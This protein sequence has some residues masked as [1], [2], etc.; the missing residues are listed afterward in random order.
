MSVEMRV[1]SMNPLDRAR[2]PWPFCRVNERPYGVCANTFTVY[3]F[4][5]T[6]PPVSFGILPLNVYL[7]FYIHL[8]SPKC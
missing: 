2:Y 8:V 1:K 4:Q 7:R 3:I 6:S 5:L